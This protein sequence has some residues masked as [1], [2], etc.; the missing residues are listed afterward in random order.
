MEGPAP[1]TWS[2]AGGVSHTRW[3]QMELRVELLGLP[4]SSGGADGGGTNESLRIEP[5]MTELRANAV[6]VP[7]P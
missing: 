5:W 3:L 4:K 7:W 6:E 2:Y 1:N